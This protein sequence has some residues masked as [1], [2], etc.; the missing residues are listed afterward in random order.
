MISNPAIKATGSPCFCY[1]VPQSDTVLKQSIETSFVVGTDQILFDHIAHQ[2]PEFVVSIRVVLSL[3]QRNFPRQA[4]KNQGPR[5]RIHDRR[6]A[7]LER[8]QRLRSSALRGTPCAREAV[9]SS[10]RPC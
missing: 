5:I 3:S 2:Q 1:D 4:S 6:E 8:H 10:G 7:A 9:W